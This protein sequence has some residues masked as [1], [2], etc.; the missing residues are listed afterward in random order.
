MTQDLCNPRVV[1]FAIAFE[2]SPHS[3]LT[4]EHNHENTSDSKG[5]EFQFRKRLGYHC[6][7]AQ[8]L[9]HTAQEKEQL[10]HK[11][12]NYKRVTVTARYTSRTFYQKERNL[13]LRL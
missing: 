11:H 9:N 13:T 2:P 7:H 1:S 3:D 6:P 10:V 5:R 4:E 8:A 12:S